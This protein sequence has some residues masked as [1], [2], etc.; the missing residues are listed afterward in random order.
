MLA[1][2]YEETDLLVLSKGRERALWKRAEIYSACSQLDSG[3]V[4]AHLRLSSFAIG[5]SEL[6]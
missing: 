4:P 5:M 2:Q 3:L 6:P 1:H